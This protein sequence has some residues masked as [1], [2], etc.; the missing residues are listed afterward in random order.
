MLL[1]TLTVF[2][3]TDFVLQPAT[4][5]NWRRPTLLSDFA[6]Y[7]IAQYNLLFTVEAIFQRDK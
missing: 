7:N 4:E 5:T 6:I 1:K 2:V 3:T